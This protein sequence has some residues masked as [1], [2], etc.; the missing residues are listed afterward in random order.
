[1]SGKFQDDVLIRLFIGL[2]ILAILTRLYTLA[3]L[4]HNRAARGYAELVTRIGGRAR[5]LIMAV[6]LLLLVPGLLAGKRE[7]YGDLVWGLRLSAAACAFGG[8]ALVWNAFRDP[9]PKL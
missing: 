7:K 3:F 1:M 5:T 6:F 2:G 9:N 8:L 4:R